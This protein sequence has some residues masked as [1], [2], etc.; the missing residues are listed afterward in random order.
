M[1]SRRSSKVGYSTPLL[2]V[3]SAASSRLGT[4]AL[5]IQWHHARQSKRLFG[6]GFLSMNFDEVRDFWAE[7]LGIRVQ[8]GERWVR[9]GIALI[10]SDVAHEAG[11][12]AIDG[13]G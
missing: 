9:R 11:K 5:S 13:R 10:T 6:S 2:Q 7:V 3:T 12:D 1:A 4:P 8:F